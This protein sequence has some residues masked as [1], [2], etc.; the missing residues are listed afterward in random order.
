MAHNDFFKEEFDNL[1]TENVI[2]DPKGEVAYGYLRV[3]SSEQAE[4]GRSGL[5]RQIMHIHE[6]AVRHHLK[7]PW[8]CIFADDHTGFE[9]R[10]RPALT[11]LRQEFKRS[12]R[13]AHTLV[14]EHLDRLSRNADW[15][16][17]FLLD[18]MQEYHL[19][20]FF[21]KTF[22]SRIER[23]VMGAI[24]QEGM[25][26]EK[27]RM[28]EGRIMKAQSGRV[29]AKTRAYGYIFVDSEGK[30][31]SKAKKDTYYAP[32]PKE[33]EIMRLI[34]QKV[35]YEGM[36][37]FA[38]ANYLQER[39]PPP[40]KY[41]YWQCTQLQLFIRNPL[42]KG[43][44]IANRTKEIK[45]PAKN[46]RPNQPVKLVTKKVIRP[47]EEWIIVP[48]PPLVSPEL[49]EAANRVL[50]K[51]AQMASRNGKLPY[52]LTGLLV[53][54]TCGCH[55]AGSSRY[56]RW[57]N[58]D[59][60]SQ[61]CCYRCCSRANLPSAHS[62][63]IDCTQGQIERDKLEAMV[64]LCMCKALHEPQMLLDHLDRRLKTEEHQGIEQQIRFLERQLKEKDVE[65]D[66][67]YKA[68]MA[69][70]FDAHEFAA[71]RELV[72]EA[73]AKVGQEL[74]T[75]YAQQVKQEDI[76]A[77]RALVIS[78]SQKALSGGLLVE[79]PFE[80]KQQM[81]KLLV[82]RIVI[83]TNERWFK[84]EGVLSGTFSL[85]GSIENIHVGTG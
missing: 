41:A 61:Y 40:A 72:K 42:Y 5:P 80:S 44:F 30:E 8:E 28:L 49:W 73:K 22:S 26:Q 84:I 15:H 38:L 46:Q 60:K 47:K 68:Y 50:D 65:D 66:K 78:A 16:Q 64:W 32:H 76:E 7:I 6:V 79:M 53:C 37:T 67:L 34:F 69:D 56:Y 63:D 82:D 71:R 23:A 58:S 13:L 29:T 54:A 21:W 11:R 14:I 18:E 74:S 48:V 55:Y 85:D 51:N 17:G 62:K 36:G 52:L 27:Q 3:S 4:E 2:G 35:A 83:N 12:N 24:S 9:F 19:S 25:E 45:V 39:V 75:L 1:A 70:V 20:V 10:G 59:Q 33:S 81:L 57:K 77:M 31:G 43:Q